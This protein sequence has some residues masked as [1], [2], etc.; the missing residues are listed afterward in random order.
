MGK[1]L[2]VLFGDE[3]RGTQG[4]TA[5]EELQGEGS[6]ALRGAALVE[7]DEDGL[8][9]LKRN[10]SGELLEGGLGATVSRA[11]SELLE[12]VMRDLD[13]KTF[14]LIAELEADS[15]SVGARMESLGGRMMHEWRA[16]ARDR[17]PRS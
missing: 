1:F 16:P 8:L 3:K 14:A 7:R 17:V 4:L 5:L 11:P 12:F 13:P 2:V 15:I 10:T 9:L 6:I